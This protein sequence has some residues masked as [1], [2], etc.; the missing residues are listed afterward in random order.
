MNKR[1]RIS[2]KMIKEVFSK[3]AKATEKNIPEILRH[4]KKLM[5]KEGKE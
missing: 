4:L 1:K 2:D 3:L 5:E